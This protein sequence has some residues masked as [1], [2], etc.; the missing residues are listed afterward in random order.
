LGTEKGAQILVWF[1]A[2][3]YP[4]N[5]LFVVL[6]IFPV[7]TL[8]S[9][10]SLPFAFKLCRHVLE[11]HHIPEKVSNSKFIALGVHFWNCL[12]LGV[13]FMLG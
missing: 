7:W 6:G 11:N 4:F 8:L 3:I 13:G 12:L 5:L 9:F 1:T 2:I 10:C